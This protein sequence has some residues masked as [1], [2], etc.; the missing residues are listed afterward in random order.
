ML[1]MIYENQ[2]R[3]TY[4]TRKKDWEVIVLWRLVYIYKYI[5]I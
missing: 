1:L 4:S 3:T 2:R 5:Y